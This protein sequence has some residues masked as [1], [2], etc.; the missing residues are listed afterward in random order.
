VTRPPVLFLDEPT[1]GLD[2]SSRLRMW[3]VI[4][5]LVA[6]GVTLLLTT[7]YLDEADEL[8]DRIVVIDHGHVIASGAPAELKTQTG[9]AQLEVTL[10]EANP[11]AAGALEPFAAGPVLVSQ[12]GR[13]LRAPVRSGGGLAST[14]VRALDAAGITV[15]DVEVHQPSLDDVFFA[16]TG[17]P[18]EA[19]EERDEAD[20]EVAR[21]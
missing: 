20:L 3:N 17:R 19:A 10:T 5:E 8:A 13:R 16:L 18:A 4:R 2:P 15:D 21:S 11:A 6:D 12:D 14:V 7:Q 9:G 1:T